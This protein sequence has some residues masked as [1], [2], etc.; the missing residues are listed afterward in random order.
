MKRMQNFGAQRWLGLVAALA[1]SGC[2]D[3]WRQVSNDAI[4]GQLL[5]EFS[6]L[7]SAEF[8][9]ATIGITED[10]GIEWI[11]GTWTNGVWPGGLWSS[12]IWVDGVWNAGTWRN[13]T[14]RN[15]KWRNGVWHD[16]TWRNGTWYGGTWHNGVWRKGE[17]KSGTWKRGVWYNGVWEDGVWEDG[18][19]VGGT[20]RGG[21]WNGG[22]CDTIPSSD[23]PEAVIEARR[24]LQVKI[25]RQRAESAEQER[26]LLQRLQA[27]EAAAQQ[28]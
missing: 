14:W 28:Q 7:S 23:C 24:R 3:A 22:R 10:G 1:L 12:G 2:D 5:R 21:S 17:W 8:P 26:A 15:G 20:W 4:P 18:V 6:W 27:Q 9:D 11:G 16:G 13:G 25:D 19:W